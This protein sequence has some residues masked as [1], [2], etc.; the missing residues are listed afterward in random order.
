MKQAVPNSLLVRVVELLMFGMHVVVWS[1][2]YVFAK[3]PA[4]LDANMMVPRSMQM[5]STV[6]RAAKLLVWFGVCAQ[7][8]PAVCG[9]DPKSIVLVRSSSL[10]SS[11]QDHLSRDLCKTAV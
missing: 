10:L 6:V 2:P 1:S 7:T 9:S 11:R 3:C 8:T 4:F 5:V